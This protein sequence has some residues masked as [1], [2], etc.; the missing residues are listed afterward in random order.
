MPWLHGVKTTHEQQKEP[1]YYKNKP[2]SKSSNYLSIAIHG[3]AN[4]L[5]PALDDLVDTKLGKFKVNAVVEM[6]FNPKK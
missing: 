5:S 1:N 2:F 6:I 3:A 4:D